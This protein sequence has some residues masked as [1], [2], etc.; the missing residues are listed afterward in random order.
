MP[1]F[2]HYDFNQSSKLK[3]QSSKLKAQWSMV[4]I[5]DQEQPQS[6]MFEHAIHYLIY[7]KLGS[8][9]NTG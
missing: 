7:N 9:R 1:K 8:G 6:G 2:K 5:N 3:A 4:V